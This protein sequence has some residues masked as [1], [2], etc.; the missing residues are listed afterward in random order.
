MHWGIGK[1]WRI[2]V[3]T[4]VVV[5]TIGQ[6]QWQKTEGAGP[7]FKTFM[8]RSRVLWGL[9]T[10]WIPGGACAHNYLAIKAELT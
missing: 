8:R 7:C 6:W 2:I 9:N 3:Q 4:R 1:T 5:S 10:S